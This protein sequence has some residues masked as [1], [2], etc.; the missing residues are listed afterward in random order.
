MIIFLYR[1]NDTSNYWSTT[2]AHAQM[3]SI[4]CKVGI[5]VDFDLLPLE[6]ENGV[7]LDF[8][9]G[10]IHCETTEVTCILPEKVNILVFF[11][12]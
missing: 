10:Y 3:V 6:G 2:S 1:D 9:A 4:L 7:T 12:F 8:L 5:I 11:L